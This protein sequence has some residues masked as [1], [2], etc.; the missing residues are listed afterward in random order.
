M[1]FERLQWATISESSATIVIYE[2]VSIV[3]PAYNE[4][5]TVAELVKRVQAVDLG[6]L[7]KE[8]IVVDNNSRDNTAAVARRIPGV[9]VY[10]E[11]AR[12]KG[13]AVRACLK[14]PQGLARRVSSNRIIAR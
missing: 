10:V 4:E 12:G 3:I 8:V 14:T 11:T 5:R 2:K 1:L 9:H 13:A 6:A 7:E